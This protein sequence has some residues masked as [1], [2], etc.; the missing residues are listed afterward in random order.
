MARFFRWV[1]KEHAAK[2]IELGLVSHNASALWI[3]DLTG[4]YRPSADISRNAY[5][6]AYDLDDTATINVSTRDHIDFESSD[7]RGEARHPAHVI[8]KANEPGAYGLGKMR[9]GLTNLHATTGYATRKEVAKALGI[10]EREVDNSYKPPGVGLADDYLAREISSPRPRGS[11][12]SDR[13]VRKPTTTALAH[14]ERSQNSSASVFTIPALISSSAVPPLFP[15]DRMGQA[16]RPNESFEVSVHSCG[17]ATSRCGQRGGESGSKV[18]MLELSCRHK[19]R[20]TFAR[21]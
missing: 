7:F 2:A 15:A 18:R 10:Q 20:V 6:L 8:V 16:L 19:S 14:S 9:Q 17:S 5:L 4:T 1:P 3:F 11:V 21:H 12:L 13:T